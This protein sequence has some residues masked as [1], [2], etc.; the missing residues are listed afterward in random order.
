MSYLKTL[1]RLATLRATL[2]W[3]IASIKKAPWT[4]A[5][6]NVYRGLRHWSASSVASTMLRRNRFVYL[7]D[8]DFWSTP[9]V[10][11]DAYRP[12]VGEAVPLV[13]VNKAFV[14]G[15]P[16]E[17]LV[18][19]VQ[20]CDHGASLARGNVTQVFISASSVI[21]DIA[22]DGWHIMTVGDARRILEGRSMMAS[23]FG[24]LTRGN[25]WLT[26]V[27]KNADAINITKSLFAFCERVVAERAAI[28]VIYTPGLP[29]PMRLWRLSLKWIMP[30]L[31][32]TE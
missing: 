5:A 17:S 8:A 27:E 10:A 24:Y 1:L 3:A 11:S 12:H 31:P 14:L 29:T 4:L 22:A 23:E 9:R 13:R 7:V 2:S 19:Q 26:D 21:C 15:L 6:R 32:P 20:F 28:L 30:P 18:S 16:A 25:D